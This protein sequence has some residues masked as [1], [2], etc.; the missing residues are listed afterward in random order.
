MQIDRSGEI[1]NLLNAVRQDIQRLRNEVAGVAQVAVGNS[2]HIQGTL[3]EVKSWRVTFP[4]CALT[5][6]TR[7]LSAPLQSFGNRNCGPGAGN[8]D[9]QPYWTDI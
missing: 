3:A 4:A 6:R 5:S 8:V 2:D 9:F 1:I 7:P